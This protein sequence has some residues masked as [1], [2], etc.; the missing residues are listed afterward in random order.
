V[1]IVIGQLSAASCQLSV[2]SCPPYPR[3]VAAVC[4]ENH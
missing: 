3:V 1:R 4:G 2:V